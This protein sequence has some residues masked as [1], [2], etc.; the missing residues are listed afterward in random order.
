MTDR[1]LTAFEH[2][3]DR[4]MRDPEFADTHA[5]YRHV[6][7]LHEVQEGIA[8]DLWDAADRDRGPDGLHGAEAVTAALDAHARAEDWVIEREIIGR[9]PP[10]LVHE[11]RNGWAYREAKVTEPLNPAKIDSGPLSTLHWYGRASG[12]ARG[13]P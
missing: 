11:L 7:R 2:V 3:Q 1:V 6:R 4:Y 13:F 8:G 10:R 5:R 9:L 12:G